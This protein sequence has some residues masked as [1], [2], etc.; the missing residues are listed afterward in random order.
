MQYYMI[1]LYYYGIGEILGGICTGILSDL[2]DKSLVLIS[3]QL[4]TY[5]AI[6]CGVNLIS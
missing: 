5:V 4:L 1:C 3:I 2:F 6:L